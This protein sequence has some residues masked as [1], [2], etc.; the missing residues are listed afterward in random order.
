[1][2]L[3]EI[4]EDFEEVL[5]SY[6]ERARARSL[7]VRIVLFRKT[8]RGIEVLAQKT[9]KGKILFP[10]GMCRVRDREP[11]E[12]L[13]RELEEE[14]KADRRL[15]RDLRNWALL[16][17]YSF[18]RVNWG[19][20]VDLLMVTRWLPYY[21]PLTRS[22]DPETACMI[23]LPL[24]ALDKDDTYKNV[25]EGLQMLIDKWPALEY[26]ADNLVER[27]QLP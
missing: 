25:V 10:G 20:N 7:Y 6:A 21:T 13:L 14:T 1:M 3:P 23:W 4:S 11:A 27:P 24:K 15:L 26:Y 9:K 5:D 12:A 22:K 2:E 17:Y 8:S 19:K 18:L 16:W